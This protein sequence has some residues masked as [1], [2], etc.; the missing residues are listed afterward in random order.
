LAVESGVI[1]SN[2]A[3]DLA[4]RA[5]KAKRLQLP[6]LAQFNEFI[7]AMRNAKTR[8]SEHCADLAQGLDGPS[9]LLLPMG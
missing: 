7:E 2:P 4:R 5:Q 8:S 9:I 1:Y 3:A 6:T